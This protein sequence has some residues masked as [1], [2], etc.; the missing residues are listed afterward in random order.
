V[1]WHGDYKAGSS[2]DQFPKLI[3]LNR[4]VNGL[5]DDNQKK[6]YAQSVNSLAGKLGIPR[7][8]VD[9]RHDVTHDKLCDVVLLRIAAQTALKFCHE[10]YWKPLAISFCH[11]PEFSDIDTLLCTQET[12]CT[13]KHCE[14][15][16]NS[17]LFQ[18]KEYLRISLSHQAAIL[19]R[20]F[21]ILSS[22]CNMN[23]TM[24]WALM[25]SFCENSP[26]FLLLFALKAKHYYTESEIFRSN[27]SI[28][29][30]SM[31]V[32][33]HTHFLPSIPRLTN[34]AVDLLKILYCWDEANVKK[35][36]PLL[37]AGL[38]KC[39]GSNILAAIQATTT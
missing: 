26:E 33:L 36:C 24:F 1:L 18:H 8:I 6:M 11:F 19:S 12:S 2:I 31:E 10:S 17:T 15:L 23:E 28:V 22:G 27:F 16:I 29:V 35:L 14:K 5:I 37:L 13:M 34:L 9:I 32:M 30:R 21:N 25:C 4:F 38:P 7:F 39:A 20:A 3:P